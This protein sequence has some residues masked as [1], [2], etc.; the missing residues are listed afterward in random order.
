ML[1]IIF[2][3]DEHTAADGSYARVMKTRKWLYLSSAASLIISMGFYDASSTTAL[4]KVIKLPTSLVA[5]A[6]A[7]AVTYLLL[8][9]IFLVGQLISTYDIV[10]NDRFIFRRADELASATE[11]VKDNRLQLNAAI[12]QFNIDNR[13]AFESRERELTSSL[14]GVES[15][16]ESAEDAI[17]SSDV[18][19]FSEDQIQ[20]L[21]YDI[22]RLNAMR[23]VSSQN[24]H[25][26]REDR[27]KELLPEHDS[28]VRMAQSTL[29]ESER[30]FAVLQ[31]Q[32]PSQRRGYQLA[33]RLI[34]FS[35]IT[36]PALSAIAAL[37]HFW[38]IWP[39]N[40]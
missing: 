9:Y 3:D 13:S 32:V 8:Q 24:L 37:L 18:I 27:A 30:A 40:G 12:A 29:E 35:R 31:H 38:Q 7:Y 15:Q 14:T 26:L 2:G 22:A 6:M 4:V 39:F 25:K 23:A 20:K 1:Q 36:I 10:L 19:K 21:R 5:P 16:I 17:A 33:E 28:N 11:R 34:D